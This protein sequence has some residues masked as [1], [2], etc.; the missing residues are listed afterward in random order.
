MPT[1]PPWW[2]ETPARAAGGFDESVQNRPVRDG[3]GAVPHAFGLPVG[4]AT[5]VQVI[6]ADR[7]GYPTAPHEVV[8]EEAAGALFT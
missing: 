3:V 8:E 1:P 5:A 6:P 4:A 7:S 2:T